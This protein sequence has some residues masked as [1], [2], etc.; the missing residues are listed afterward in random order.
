LRRSQRRTRGELA[1]P[2]TQGQIAR[3]R[4]GRT[5]SAPNPA[6]P[7]R[8][9][10]IYKFPGP[11]DAMVAREALQLID[12]DFLSI[13]FLFFWEFELPLKHHQREKPLI[14]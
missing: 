11:K 2:V 14:F 9:A 4:R 1:Q 12:Y 13:G 7:Q 3:Y 6:V 10:G 8:P 5:S